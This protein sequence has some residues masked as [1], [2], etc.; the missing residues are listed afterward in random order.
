MRRYGARAV[1]PPAVYLQR[2]QPDGV[3]PLSLTGERTLPDVPEENY[4]YRRHLVVY[5]W[6]A[7]RAHGRRVVD[8][9]CGEGYGS[10][11][12]G[13]T[14]ESVVGVDANPEAFEHARLKYTG[15][16]VRFERNMIELW[17]GDVD[18]VVFLQT[19]EHVQDPDAVLERVRELIGP[20]GVAYVSTPNVLTLAPKGAER[21]GNPWHVRE[22]RPEEFRALCARHFASVDLLGLFHARKLRL[23]QLAIE[24]AG[25]DPIHR[26]LRI[27]GPFYDRFTPAIS[28]RDFRLRRDRL[29][30]ALDLLAV[31]RP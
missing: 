16:N 14:A 10:A 28:E 4:W 2:D 21:S 29:E 8:L 19:I 22:Y 30:R 17:S 31:L 3:P 18:C 11:V 20:R 6:I 7:A 23:H 26:A 12:L 13:R 24:R 25:W 1:D 5:E 15:A 9:A 27:T